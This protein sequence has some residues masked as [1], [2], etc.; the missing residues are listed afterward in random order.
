MKQESDRMKST[1]INRMQSQGGVAVTY[2]QECVVLVF[3]KLHY[4]SL[5]TAPITV[6]GS[7]EDSDHVAI[8][9]PVVS[10]HDELMGACNESYV[11]GMVELVA[12]ILPKRV[13]GATRGDTSK[14][15]RTWGLRAE[16]PERGRERGS[17]REY[18]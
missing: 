9:A 11:V 2:L 12:N 3:V 16:L 6:V 14:A 18:Q 8:M 17:G 15:S 4:G 13:A 10:L 1:I 7:G 5:V